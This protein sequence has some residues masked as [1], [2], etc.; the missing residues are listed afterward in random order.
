MTFEEAL[1]QVPYSIPVVPEVHTVRD[2]DVF[3]GG[4]AAR[5][6]LVWHE[7]SRALYPDLFDKPAPQFPILHRPIP[8][9]VRKLAAFWLL[10]NAYATLPGRA[11]G[12][13]MYLT[14]E[15]DEDSGAVVAAT[16]FRR[17]DENYGLRK[18]SSAADAARF[19]KAVPSD[20]S[21]YEAMDDCNPIGTWLLRGGAK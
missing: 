7:L 13:L 15:R 9:D 19:E 2:G 8:D 16:R 20:F 18:F 12:W 10:Y 21:W 3:P 1:D 17:T 5:G 4:A 11:T 6:E 14:P